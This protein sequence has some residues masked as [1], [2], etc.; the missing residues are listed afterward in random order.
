MTS[1]GFAFRKG[2]II[3]LWSILWGIIGAIIGAIISGGSLM[4]MFMDPTALLS[5]TAMAGAM[6]G[7]LAGIFIGSLIAL[8]GMYAA[9]V[10]I[11]TEAVEELKR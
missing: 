3:W 1:W 4:T 6:L 7:M 10:K 2:L 9:M 11:I 8:I 5:P